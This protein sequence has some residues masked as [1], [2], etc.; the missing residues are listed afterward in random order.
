[1][2]TWGTRA[3]H[4]PGTV[5][6]YNDTRVNLLALAATAVWRRPLPAVLA[7]HVMGPI[8]ASSTWQWHGYENSWITLDGQRV[9]AVSGGSHWG[10]GLFIHAY[11]LARFGLLTLRGGR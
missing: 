2:S 5:Y 3:R 10:G 9:Q 4:E 6:E 11:D 8:G 1:P 7:E